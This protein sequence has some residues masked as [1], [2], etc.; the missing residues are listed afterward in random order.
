MNS[1]VFNSNDRSVVNLSSSH[2]SEHHISLLQR[3]LKFCP[4]PPAPNAGQLREDMD[5]FHTR[6]RQIAYFDTMASNLNQSTSFISNTPVVPINPMASI[7]PF[8]H[9][10]FKLKSNWRVPTGPVNLE[11][12]I[13]CNEQQYNAR[14]IFKPSFRSNI[15][16]LERKA[17]KELMGN[18]N[19][20]IKP[21]DKGSAVV[22]MDRI[23]YLKEGYRQLSDVKFYTRLD[24][25][26]TLDFRKEVSDFVEDMHQNGEI[27]ESVQK[28]LMYDTYRTPQLYLLPKIHKGKNPPPGRPIISANGCPTEN[29]S[30]FVDFFLNPTCSSLPSFVKDT[31]HFLK[32]IK[33][34]GQLPDG[35]TLVT[36][37]VTSL[38]TN[39]PNNEG[40]TAARIALDTYRPQGNIKP[41]NASLIRLL[42]MVLTKN[43]FQFNGINFLQVGGTAMGTKVAPSFA[44]TYMGS[45]E[46]EHV[47]TYRLQPTLYL[48]YIDDIFMIWPHGL[49]ELELFTHHMNN[50]NQHIQF[51][52]EISSSEI[53]FLDTLVKLDRGTLTTD[54][55][56]KPTDSHNYLYYNSA[57]PQRCKD[58][59]PYS[60]F[61]RIR[62]I[63]SDNKDFDRHV[64]NLASHFLRRKYPIE[65]IKDA[66]L[67]ARE[68]DR[69]TLLTQ[70][71]RE[72]N[73]ADKDKVFLI[74][75]Y[76]P[77]DQ[78]V[79]DIT[80][81][82]WPLLGRNQATENLFHKKLTCGYRRP[83]NL[84]DLL[85]RAKVGKLPGDELA[86]PTYDPTANPPVA[87]DPA[88]VPLRIAKKQTTMHDFL[89]KT[90]SETSI[91]NTSSTPLPAR[92]TRIPGPV[93]SP[94][95]KHKRGFPFCGAT[96]ACK[97][98]P[99]LNKT[100]TIKSTTTG[101]TYP[102]MRNVSCRSSNVIYAITCTVCGKQYV[103][104]TLLQLQ[105]RFSGHFGD[106]RRN[107]QTK[108][109]GA[110]FTQA[111]HNRK[112]DIQITILEF[113]K[114]PPRSPQAIVI[115]HR[116]ESKWTHTLRTLA[117][118]GLNLENPKEYCSHNKK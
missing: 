97:Y 72:P 43:N 65:T 9:L 3:G 35:C 108:P 104:Q 4:T 76:H 16:H 88:P 80:R 47:Y 63:C 22:V 78:C 29:I 86:D 39:I 117:P 118:Q 57:H 55:Y 51:T 61:L 34:L 85:C 42:E 111:G 40:L 48:R 7:E 44:V 113:I 96:K 75:T 32:L 20:I 14:P 46:K 93:G 41:T 11:A 102:A 45:F 95:R 94:G 58:S 8:K 36:M 62:R 21:A 89:Q 105:E 37:D 68:Q 70:T 100:G 110:H 31:T 91:S 83:K 28:Y 60:Q 66:A 98:C 38:Y 2:L 84:R 13:A 25:D 19:I 114:K 64:V 109:V 107:D 49:H 52:S 90:S 71:E 69:D 30:Q 12:M 24:H 116:V 81:H 15:D 1:T 73:S 103:G 92:A 23:D 74:T 67:L 112:S 54:L 101:L 27:D 115:R 10:K 99:Y 79:P 106:I 17:M 82:N 26:P 5:R 50:C 59:I 33:N 53:P 77:D 56:T 87:P 18:K 6:L